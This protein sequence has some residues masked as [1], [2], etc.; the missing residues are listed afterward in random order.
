MNADDCG[1]GNEN[2]NVL[3]VGNNRNVMNTNMRNVMNNNQLINNQP[4]NNQP[5]NNQAINNQGV[6]NNQPVNVNN[7]L[8][9]NNQSV[10][11]NQVANKNQKDIV[12]KSEV[13][14]FL[15]LLSALAV[16]ES[17]KY[18]INKSIRLNNGTSSTYI[19]YAVICVGLLVVYNML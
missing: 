15:A 16:N 11:N 3:N 19:Y 4:V 1:C 17:V 10:N 18:F 13:N 14:M 7:N 9:S 12:N 6:N 8:G 5:V 2:L